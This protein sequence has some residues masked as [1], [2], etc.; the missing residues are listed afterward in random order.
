MKNNIVIKY[1]GRI[2]LHYPL[3]RSQL[4]IFCIGNELTHAI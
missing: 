2:S 3:N 4:N 1:W